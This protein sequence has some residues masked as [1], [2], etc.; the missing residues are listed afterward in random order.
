[1]T[2]TVTRD[3]LDRLRRRLPHGGQR[4]LARRIGVHPNTIMNALSGFASE[5]VI[6]RLVSEAEALIAEHAAGITN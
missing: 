6:A 2:K 3:D 4:E 5:A 1:M